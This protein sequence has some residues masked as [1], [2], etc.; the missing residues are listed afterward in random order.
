MVRSVAIAL[1]LAC[2][3]NTGSSDSGST[4]DAA[5]PGKL[6]RV[7]AA[8]FHIH[9][10]GTA[11]PTVLLDGGAGTWSTH[12]LHVQQA[13]AEEAT[14]CLYDRAGLGWSDPSASPRT[15]KHMA[16][17]L[18]QLIHEAALSPPLILVGHSLG[19]LNVRLLAAE[20]PEDVAGLVLIESAH[21]RQWAELPPEV[22]AL[23]ESAPTFIRSFAARARDG[24]LT[25][26][27]AEAQVSPAFAAPQR[28]ALVRAYLTEKP[29]NGSAAEFEG[30]LDA[31]N[32]PAALG[33]LPLVVLTASNSYGAFGDLGIPVEASNRV[34]MRLQ[35]ELAGLSTDS[36]HR[37]ADGTH[38]LHETNLADI[39][40]AV[41]L[42][43]EKVRSAERKPAVLGYSGEALR[44][45]S[46]RTVDGLLEA[47][48]NAYNGM[49]GP[50]FAALYTDDVTQLDVNRR[51][52][53]RGK[54]AWRR[55]I[56]RVN[57]AH[58]RMERR[59]F[60]RALAGDWVIVEIEWSGTLREQALGPGSPRTDY[61]FTGLG[62]LQ[63]SGGQIRT[64]VLYSDF[65]TLMAQLAATP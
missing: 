9:C 31:G 57:A 27:E 56:D 44:P 22:R 42:A 61:R 14:V 64:Q 13:L 26:T 60:G 11:R 52:H 4:G 18:H 16:D 41:R 33:A 59:H 53:L 17:E 23:V 50:A 51:V 36:A 54:D 7:G 35:K 6:V 38:A 47:L 62:L 34:W 55:Q 40:A 39:A 28:E 8:V 32:G 48:E 1:I 24:S 20:Y 12:Y 21:E 30:A 10:R 5:P 2:S 58:L 29:Y 65:A 46:T 43:A 63:T 25:L 37:I 45:T 15:P 19:G 3:L 49:D